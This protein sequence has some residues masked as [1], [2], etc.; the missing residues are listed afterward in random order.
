[1]FRSVWDDIKAEIRFGNTL[2]RLILINIGLWMALVLAK[3]IW[4]DHYPEL[5]AN[6]FISSDLSTLIRKPWTILTHMFLHESFWHLL[7][8]MLALFWFG[9]IVGDFI[10]DRRIWPIYLLGG[11]CGVLFFTIG[12]SMF[13]DNTAHALGSSAA[14]MAFVTASAT[15][16]PNYEMRLFLIGNVKIKYIALFVLIIDLVGIIQ[17][18]NS[19][20]HMA[21]LGGYLFGIIFILMLRRGIDLSAPF[22]SVKRIFKPASKVHQLKKVY[23]TTAPGKR[24]QQKSAAT[25]TQNTDLSYQEKV[26]MILDKINEKGYQSLTPDEKAFLNEASKNMDK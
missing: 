19:G 5:A 6:L 2:N 14:V 20:G 7:F 17:S 18:T 8:N 23:S 22:I 25:G 26:D 15:L 1:M 24:Y 21:H 10:G 12:Y 13:F 9:N 11:L 4:N 3:V 16:S